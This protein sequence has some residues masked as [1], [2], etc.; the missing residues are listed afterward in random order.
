LIPAGHPKQPIEIVHQFVAKH[1]QSVDIHL[2]L[3][4]SDR[5]EDGV[6]L[7][8]L[9]N[10]ELLREYEL[11][12]GGTLEDVQTSVDLKPG[13]VLEISVGPNRSSVGDVTQYRFTLRDAD[14]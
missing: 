3:S 9:I 8:A 11:V 1:A 10:D 14:A 12:P 6:M 5:S 13:D 7:V 4:V 2:K